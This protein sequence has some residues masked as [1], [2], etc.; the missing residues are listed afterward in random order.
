[1]RGKI[2]AALIGAFLLGGGVALTVE[3]S[4]ERLARREVSRCAEV[5][6]IMVL[7]ASFNLYLNQPKD[8]WNRL[9][10]RFGAAP[11]TDSN[12][13]F[14]KQR[15]ALDPLTDTAVYGLTLNCLFGT[16]RR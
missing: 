9:L 11:A 13:E 3:D 12:S 2:I 10:G 4:P 15:Y 7:P 8:Y 6:R 1:M 5:A 16:N 14:L